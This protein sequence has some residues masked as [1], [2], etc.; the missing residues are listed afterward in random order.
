MP[1]TETH[2]QLHL[3]VPAKVYA[4]LQSMAEKAGVSRPA[5]A[6]Q[7]LLAAYTA[8]CQVTGDRDLDA[9]VSR[10]VLMAGLRDYDT[11][12]IAAT[13]GLSEATV[14]RIRDAWRAE[15]SGRA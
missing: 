2:S 5:Y 8:R 10:V 4:R 12:E 3:K 14:V 1:N 15:I 11:A 13:V 9:A 6:E 7:L